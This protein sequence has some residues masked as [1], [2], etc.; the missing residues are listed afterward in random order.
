MA[1]VDPGRIARHVSESDDTKI[2]DKRRWA[3]SLLYLEGRQH[4][5]WDTT[6]ER[7]LA[8]AG[9]TRQ[10]TIN[11]LLLIYRNIASRFI[12]NYPGT[13]SI[14]ASPSTEDLIKAQMT[15][16]VVR[17][18]WLNVRLPY[19]VQKMTGLLLTCGLSGIHTYWDPGKKCAVSEAVD[20][21]N[22][23]AESGC[24]D[25]DESDLI[26]IRRYS[27]KAALKK[28]WP[29][30]KDVI[31]A[32]VEVD[33][34]DKRMFG[35]P[36]STMSG[37]LKRVEWFETY[38]RD[39]THAMTTKNAVL[40]KGKSPIEATAN[41]G[42]IP[43]RIVGYTPMPLRLWPLSL[44]YPLIEPQWLYN[45]TRAQIEGN[46]E[47]MGNPKMLIPKN[48]GI[49]SSSFT[50][51]PGE[52]IYYN[53]AA[54]EPKQL[55]AAPLPGY[56][57]ES[58]ARLLS[59]MHD[60]AGVHSV[61]LGKRSVGVHSGEAIRALGARDSSQLQLTQEGIIKAVE[62]AGNDAVILTRENMDESM[63]VR[64][65]DTMGSV[66]Y[67]ELQK[68][69]LQQT[70]EVYIEA[71][72]MFRDEIQDRDQ[73]TLDM[74]QAQ[75]ITPQEA[76]RRLETHETSTQFVKYAAQMSHAHDVLK[77]IAYGK[78]G[79]TVEVFESDDLAAFVEVFNEF[80]RSDDFYKLAEDR[81]DYVRDV[82]AAL[83]T[84]GDPEKAARMQVDQLVW[85]VAPMGG[86]QQMAAAA[87]APQSRLG[88][89]QTA[90]AVAQMAGERQ[91][92]A[93]AASLLNEEPMANKRGGIRLGALNG[94]GGGPQ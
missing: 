87:V 36:Y 74:L 55:Q 12:V 35:R 65:M 45:R 42:N 52:K 40:W 25:W 16:L 70:P 77:A 15:N 78:P 56:V 64:M 90:E 38:W 81:Q 20:P 68:T 6:S 75:M 33:P 21:F 13:S 46:V 17:N 84:R 44:I 86:P 48:A 47:L 94:L 23:F 61:S 63:M 3:L 67:R 28:T 92:A 51:R 30:H 80:L 10:V 41:R 89:Q 37:S 2:T 93:G 32:C 29:K 18:H 43:I 19:I 8:E 22:L 4:I 34:T 14:P 24:E 88:E 57:V 1:T 76:L 54:R 82:F 69:H 26:T 83:I 58:V 39:G 31:D 79:T 11:H 50:N 71:G 62:E 7:Y 27:T 9:R 66:M 5:R 60:I 49:P 72:S 85:P 73:K 59:E 91:E 53:G